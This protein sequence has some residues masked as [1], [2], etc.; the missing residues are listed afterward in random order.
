MWTIR[1]LRQ[2]NLTTWKRSL[3][4]KAVKGYTSVLR[5]DDIDTAE[6]YFENGNHD[7]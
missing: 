7:N 6:Y 5:K 2:G 1:T 3:H 4:Q